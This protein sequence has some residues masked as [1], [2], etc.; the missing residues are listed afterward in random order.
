ML[1]RRMD[2]YADVKGYMRRFIVILMAGL[3]FVGC[4]G[5]KAANSFEAYSVVND[6]LKAQMDADST[7]LC[8]L[9]CI[10]ETSSSQD[11][12]CIV[13]NRA[14]GRQDALTVYDNGTVIVSGALMQAPALTYFMDIMGV[15]P[16]DKLPTNHGWTSSGDLDSFIFDY[17]HLTGADSITIRECFLKSSRWHMVRYAHDNPGITEEFVSRLPDYFGEFDAHAAL[18]SKLDDE[19][20]FVAIAGGYGLQLSPQQIVA[21]YDAI[22]NGGVQTGH[23]NLNFK[24]ICTEGTASVI[25]QLLLKNVAEGT[26]RMLQD[27]TVPIAGK[28]GYRR[29]PENH[30]IGVSSFCGF[31]PGGK[32]QYTMLVSLIGPKGNDIARVMGLY[33]E[34][35]E[36]LYK[37][38]TAQ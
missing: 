21:Y 31:F 27:C 13:M 11:P 36:N 20:N 1:G 4:K 24:R 22:A 23:N 12:L 17:Q 38:T 9:V 35:A 28:T 37:T 8:G 7:S 10:K 18:R 34:I 6:L 30:D 19:R 29:Y 26:G 2:Y 32:P 16:E 33:K 5:R 25:K 15:T 3:V 14:E